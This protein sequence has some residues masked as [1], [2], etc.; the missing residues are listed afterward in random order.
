MQPILP[1]RFHYSLH[2]GVSVWLGSFR[3][4]SDR[5]LFRILSKRVLFRVLGD[6]VL[7]KV[8]FRVL[9]SRFLVCCVPSVA[10]TTWGVLQWFSVLNISI[11]TDV[12]IRKKGFILEFW[13]GSEHT[14][15]ESFIFRSIHP[16]VFRKIAFLKGFLKFL[17][18]LPWS[19]TFQRSCGPKA[20]LLHGCYP[21][22]QLFL[23]FS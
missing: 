5:V 6:R 11:A 1:Y 20:G 16:E 23:T 7:F 13:L 12:L 2:G 4:L 18:K 14:S 10:S 3:V 17:E 21:V 22:K 8:L 15:A 9:S 19:S